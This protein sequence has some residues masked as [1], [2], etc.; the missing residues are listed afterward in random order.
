MNLNEY[1]RNVSSSLMLH[2][3]LLNLRAVAKSGHDP[4][5]G[6]SGD[7]GRS[8]T[9]ISMACEKRGS[10]VGTNGMP[11]LLIDNNK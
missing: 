2:P 7:H 8:N 3:K 4:R 5:S 11:A 1:N 10:N 9:D 6:T